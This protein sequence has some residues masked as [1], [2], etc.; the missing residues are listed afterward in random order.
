[1][2]DFCEDVMNLIGDELQEI[3]A[4]LIEHASLGDDEVCFFRYLQYTGAICFSYRNGVSCFVSNDVG[5]NF[6]QFRSWPSLWT[7][8]GMDKGINTLDGMAEYISEF[9]SYYHESIKYVGIHMKKYFV[10][11]DDSSRGRDI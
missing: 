6:A 8:L 9:P 3:G 4:T 7:L 11:G 2:S 1:M 10:L 5:A